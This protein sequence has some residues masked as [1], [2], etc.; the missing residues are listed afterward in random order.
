MLLLFFVPFLNQEISRSVMLGRLV[1]QKRLCGHCTNGY[2][3]N[4]ESFVST[5]KM[6]LRGISNIGFFSGNVGNV[7]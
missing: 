6:G 4:K 1:F 3:Q 2:E 5:A 7:D